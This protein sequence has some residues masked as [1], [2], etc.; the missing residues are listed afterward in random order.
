M[1]RGKRVTHP[2]TTRARPL[3][4]QYRVLEPGDTCWRWGLAQHQL[5]DQQAGQASRSSISTHDSGRSTYLTPVTP[6]PPPRTSRYACLLKQVA[7]ACSEYGPPGLQ[8]PS[9]Q[10]VAQDASRDS[11]LTTSNT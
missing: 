2:L 7:R 5:Q 9:S 1:G 8:G 4:A 10:G 11:V 6:P 3:S